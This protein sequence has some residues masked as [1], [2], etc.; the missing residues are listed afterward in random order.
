M[1]TSAHRWRNRCADAAINEPIHQWLDDQ[2]DA[3]GK[4]TRSNQIRDA[5]NAGSGFECELHNPPTDFAD[6]KNWTVDAL[7]VDLDLSTAS[8]GTSVSYYGSTL[9]SEMRVRRPNI[10]V[11]LTTGQAKERWRVQ[12]LD[13]DGDADLIW[14]KDEIIERVDD[15][16]VELRNLILGFRSLDQQKIP[17]FD[18]LM[19]ILGAVDADER[20]LLRESG[21]PLRR[22]PGK[23]DATE[24]QVPNVARWLRTVVLEYPGVMYDAATAA[25]RLGISRESFDNPK[26]RELF[27]SALYRGPLSEAQPHWWRDR[28]LLI[29]YDVVLAGGMNGILPEV[30]GS[31][32]EQV[33][34]TALE[35]SR[36]VVDGSQGASWLCHVLRKPVQISNSLTY[37]PDARPSVMEQARVSFEAIRKSSLFDEALVDP[38]DRA[39]VEQIWDQNP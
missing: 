30:F 36:C 6:L 38:Q 39:F 14:F 28:L 5:I 31:A 7:L 34:S 25:A 24:W 16:K 18:T 12:V 15:F 17:D 33:H 4:D 19:T 13:D 1:A 10:P 3:Q 11:I 23:L 26:V 22:R 20:R 9:A 29:A 32:F 8:E 2:I 21:L 37:F 35:P 27:E